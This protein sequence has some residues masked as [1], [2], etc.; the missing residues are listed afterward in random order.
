MEAHESIIRKRE[1][2]MANNQMTHPE[3]TTVNGQRYYRD[4]SQQSKTSRGILIKVFE[5]KSMRE[6]LNSYHDF[7]KAQAKAN[8]EAAIKIT[9]DYREMIKEHY[10]NI[11]KQL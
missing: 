7:L 10:K 9:R 2:K 1:S 6:S 5:F 3:H 8:Y 4:Y 11:N